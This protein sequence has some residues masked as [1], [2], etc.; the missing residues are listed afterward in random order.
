LHSAANAINYAA[1]GRSPIEGGIVGGVSSISNHVIMGGVDTGDRLG[2]FVI[3]TT[4]SAMVGGSTSAAMGG[5]F[6]DGAAAG[7]RIMLMNEM[8]KESKRLIKAWEAQSKKSA[9]CVAKPETKQAGD[10][11]RN[12]LGRKVYHV[13]CDY[14]CISP[15]GKKTTITGYREVSFWSESGDELAGYNTVYDYVTSSSNPMGIFDNP[16]GIPFD[17]AESD[18]PELVDWVKKQ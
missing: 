14:Q 9:L 18:V 12:W 8:G 2:D 11:Q 7:A 4:L 1:H 13:K 6:A 15:D 16:Q 5:R 3:R 17:P 10:P